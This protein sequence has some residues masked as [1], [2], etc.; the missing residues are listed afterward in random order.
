MLLIAVSSLLSS[1]P[2]S[3][4][5]SA[6]RDATQER[7][8]TRGW[9]RYESLSTG[10]YA[11][12]YIPFSLELS[13]PLPVVVFLHGSGAFPENW[14]SL[15]APVAEKAGVVVLLPKS[16]SSLGFGV[17]ADDRTIVESLERLGGE[18][19][20]DPARIALAG[21]SSGGAYAAV[22]AYASPGQTDGTRISAVFTLGIPYR[23]VLEVADP[24][25]TAPLRMYYG[26]EDPN[27]W[28]SSRD[29]LV[30]QWQRL[31]IPYQEDL[32][33]GFGHSSW[34]D[35]T[36]EAGFEFLRDQRYSTLGGCLPTGERLCLS[37]GRFSAEVSWRKPSGEA[38][39]G[40]VSEA[41]TAD[42]G[43]FWF[44]KEENWELQV[45]VLDGCSSNGHF[46]VFTAGST[47]VAYTLTV[48]DMLSDQV[49]IYEN[50]QGKLAGT[51]AD[52]EAFSVCP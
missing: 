45:K 30:E 7:S 46:W 15:I 3:A 4:S 31:G 13:E 21:H 12:R 6:A 39:R 32:A 33:S 27:F 5:G 26:S 11:Y 14:R 23:T 16:V 19:A 51:V 17:G 49:W 34:P 52:I 44:F 42:S 43:L 22:L 28:G 40:G 10:A 50:A 2:V 36:L 18:V 24:D 47:N 37:E 25:Y 8:L 48:T 20:I 29:A 9:L 38:G 35:G 1:A 41:R